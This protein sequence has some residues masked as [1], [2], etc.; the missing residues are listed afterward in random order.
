MTQSPR[1]RHEQGMDGHGLTTT[2]DD[3]GSSGVVRL[4]GILAAC[5]IA[6]AGLIT[7]AVASHGDVELPA[8]PGSGAV[9][10]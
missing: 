1:R 7:A 5:A 8:D 10:P 6:T 3:A 4:L 2:G 9:T